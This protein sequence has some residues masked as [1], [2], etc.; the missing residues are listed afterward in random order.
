[1]RKLSRVAFWGVIRAPQSDTNLC[2]T[3]H[4]TD[5]S[6]PLINEDLPAKPQLVF[7][8][9][10]RFNSTGCALGST[11]VCPVHDFPPPSE[12]H[13]CYQPHRQEVMP[14]QNS[15]YETFLSLI[16]QWKWTRHDSKR[17][18]SK[19]VVK[20]KAAPSNCGLITNL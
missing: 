6:S 2:Y 9:H 4:S 15:I 3:P 11:T 5:F 14:G 13:V 19:T 7:T 20:T 18:G 16:F 12:L 1:M 10:N 17:A 8:F